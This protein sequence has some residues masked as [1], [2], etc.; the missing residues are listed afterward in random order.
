MSKILITGGTG[1]IGYH[2][3][4]RLAGQ[5]HEIVLADNFFRSRKDADLLA[6]L[7]KPNVKLIEVDLTEKS[8]W[9]KLGTG[10]DYV[11]HFV[12]INGTKLF[13][14]IPHEVLRIGV[15]TTMNAIEWFHTKNGKVGAKILYTSSNEAYASAL[16]AFGKLPLPTPEN[17]PLVIS[18]T[19]NPRWSYGGQKLIGELFFIHSSK[20]YNFRMSIVRP[21]N[22]YG[23]RAGY[24]HVIPEIAGR[25]D[26]H[27][28]PFPIFGAD[29]TRSFCYID[30]A[31]EAI[32][33]VMES[34]KTDGKTYH[35]GTHVE[36]VIQDL[37]EKMF[38]IMGWHP[39]KLDIKNSPEGSVKR[40]LPDVS[41]IKRDTG[42]EAKIELEEGLRKTID[43]YRKN[44]KPEK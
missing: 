17:V 19:Y 18:D 34:E 33:M 43:W 41:K 25:I 9:E 44:P 21:H 37:V 13:Y 11:Y 29:D 36:T 20:A 30:D 22:F 39:E 26:K 23:P 6:L 16:E 32:Q 10:Y 1:F 5:G 24:E 8:S 27:V 42:W 31:V 35:I 28:E 14:E 4:K 3:A 40:R 38:S 2:L 7:E 15:S 12:G